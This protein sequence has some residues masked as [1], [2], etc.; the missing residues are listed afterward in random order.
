MSN[1]MTFCGF[2]WLCAVQFALAIASGAAI[3]QETIDVGETGFDIKRPVLAS[4]CKNGCPWGELG[5][6]V[7]KAMK[8]M[9]Y[10]VIQCRNCN[11]AEGPRLVSKASLPPELSG[12]D[13]IVGTTTRF[14]AP[15]DF[16]ITASD[17]LDQAYR[18]AHGY[19]D[20]GPFK[21]LRLIAKIEDPF[22]LLVAVKADSGIT[23]LSQI[24]EKSLPVTILGG[25]SPISQA[26]LE[27]YDITADNLAAWGGSMGLT[28]FTT[29][30][31]QFDVIVSELGS[32]SNNPESALWPTLSQAFDLRFLKLPAELLNQLVDTDLGLQKVT[33]K[34]GLLR[35][36]ESEFK[37][38]A[39]SGE[40]VFAR[41]DTPEDAAYDIA[42]A[43]DK[44]RSDLKWFIRPYTYDSNTVFENFDVPLHPGA[45]RYYR[46]A[47]YLVDKG[48]ASDT[49]CEN[50]GSCNVTSGRSSGLPL[51]ATLCAML[52]L[53]RRRR[54][55]LSSGWRSWR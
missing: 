45:E 5:D 1:R 20:D 46:E 43:I 40:A 31:T 28:Y 2:G 22:Y 49:T 34:Y 23:D 9:G 8:P 14:D 35:G 3:A 30:D 32:P 7:E 13:T 29:P 18:G 17:M 27:Y 25:G 26:V 39:R 21:N 11:R 47:G 33:V 55:Q 19:N 42:K 50:S 41:D 38:V 37:T 53:V 54:D 16:G 52:W 51:L 44:H 48:S 36:I 6:F 15:V 4:A 10:E 12:A 24:A